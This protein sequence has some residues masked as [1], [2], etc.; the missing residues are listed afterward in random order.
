M[1]KNFFELE[2]FI[3]FKLA[4]VSCLIAVAFKITSNE[5]WSLYVISNPVNYCKFVLK[6]HLKIYD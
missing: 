2:I 4:K 6:N 3:F 1:L 5:M